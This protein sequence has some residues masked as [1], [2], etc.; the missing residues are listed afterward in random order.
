MRIAEL[1]RINAL[2]AKAK[3]VGLAPEEIIERDAL[4]RAYVSKIAGQ[5]NNMMA[6]MTVIDANGSDVTP[7]RLRQAQ[8][9]GMLQVI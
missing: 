6:V 3:S 8:A 2:A 1:D 4:R 9:R 5:V 7:A